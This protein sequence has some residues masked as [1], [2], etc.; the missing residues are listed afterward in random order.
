MTISASNGENY[1]KYSESV[2][3]QRGLWMAKEATLILVS[4]AWSIPVCS[5]WLVFLNR[6]FDV[7]IEIEC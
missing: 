3:K 4:P 2:T 6:M 1:G 5:T 7:W